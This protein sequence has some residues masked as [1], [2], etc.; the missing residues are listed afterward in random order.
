MSQEEKIS[1]ATDGNNGLWLC[2]NHHKMFDENLLMINS[3]GTIVFN[4]DL[5][6]SDITFI[7]RI[8]TN[9]ELADYVMNEQF[10]KYLSLRN[11]AL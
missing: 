5:K 10:K 3:D 2:E 9:Y 6:N 8:T 7:Q 4:G 11:E 1:F